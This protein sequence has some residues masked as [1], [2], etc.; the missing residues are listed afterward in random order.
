MNYKDTL[1]L[2]KTEF[3]L[4]NKGKVCKPNKYLIDDPYLALAE[5]KKGPSFIL[6]DGPPYAN[7][8]IHIGHAMNKILKDFIVKTHHVAGHQVQFTP[9]WDCHGLP[10]ERKVRELHPD[11]TNPVDLRLRCRDYAATQVQ[12]Q[13][14][15][16]QKLGVVADWDTPYETMQ[17]SYELD[18]F[19]SLCE[20]AEKGLL[21]RKLKPVLWSWAEKT[22]LAEAEVVYKPKKDNSVYVK[23]QIDSETSFLVWTTTPWTLPS[24]VALAYNPN[25]S[26]VIVV[27]GEKGH[28]RHILA[29]K[30]YLRLKEAG[31]FEE[32]HWVTSVVMADVAVAAVNPV[33]GQESKLIPASFVNMD[34]GMGIVHIAPGHGKDDYFLATKHNLPIIMPVD[35]NGKYTSEVK[36]NISLG[37]VHVFDGNKLIV[38][39]LK[40]TDALFHEQQIVH[41]YPYCWRSDTPVIF[42]A[43]PNWFINLD[44]IRPAVLAALDE[45]EFSPPE[46]KAKLRKMV[47]ERND[48]CISRQ[49]S[50]GVPIA[51]FLKTDGTPN[52]DPELLSAVQ[53]VFGIF[54][55]D[56]WWGRSEAWWSEINAGERCF[57]TLDVWFDSGVSWLTLE[58]EQADL[59]LEGTDQFRGWFQSS[60]LLG[61]A[62]AAAAPFKKVMSHGFVIDDKG[63]KMSKSVGNVVDPMKI[64]EEYGPDV[65]RVWVAITDYTD[66]VKIGKESLDRAKDVYQKLRNTLRFCVANI[67]KDAESPDYFLYTNYPKDPEAIDSWIALKSCEVC[68]DVH[69][70][71]LAGDFHTGMRLLLDFVVEDVSGL[72]MNSIKD[73][74]YCEPLDSFRRQSA[75]AALGYVLENLVGTLLPIITFTIDELYEHLPDYLK[76]SHENIWQFKWPRRK[77]GMP[78]S[79]DEQFWKAVHREFHAVFTELKAKELAKD[80]LDVVV[81]CD[82]QFEQ[83]GDFLGVS[84]LGFDLD[85]AL[86]LGREPLANFQVAGKTFKVYKSSLEKCPRCWKRVALAENNLCARCKTVINHATD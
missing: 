64:I 20:L 84:L 56:S 1:H 75:T 26:Y 76:N 70:K 66:D 39:H 81:S 11:L 5:P 22:A 68:T 45:I 16:F 73:R 19:A 74:M 27:S 48:W 33:N 42:R 25:E 30:C 34:E 50:W 72:Y 40:Q 6:H 38:E 36:A 78:A 71:F 55:I 47:E 79:F 59:Y 49:R 63:H 80:L 67:P 3:P 12:L 46:G 18:T 69:S 85:K 14:E 13:K 37:G 58:G 52:F 82:S 51:F 17:H 53:G 29:E 9:G 4:H 10:I 35:E 44:K 7:G 15:Q 32:V 41:D 28:V 86:L 24:N 60:L 2:P 65:L 31:L 83:D 43:T 21:Q 62:L 77:V 8:S 57:D 54:G 61:V 23:F